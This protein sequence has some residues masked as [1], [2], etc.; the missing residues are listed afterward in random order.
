MEAFTSPPKFLSTAILTT[1][2]AETVDPAMRVEAGVVAAV[3]A[4]AEH[5]A[6]N[7]ETVLG[8]EVVE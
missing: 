2:N 3:E 5:G 6:C 7:P 4:F 8:M 1:V